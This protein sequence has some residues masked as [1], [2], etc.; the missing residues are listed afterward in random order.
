MC[1]VIMNVP[2]P[3]IPQNTSS[4]PP[5]LLI[6]DRE[7]KDRDGQSTKVG[8]EQGYTLWLIL[9]AQWM[10]SE[11]RW[12]SYAIYSPANVRTQVNI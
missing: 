4:L 5:F 9:R 2:L 8:Q 6:G 10:P 12:K 11:Q 7:S 3:Q 1:C